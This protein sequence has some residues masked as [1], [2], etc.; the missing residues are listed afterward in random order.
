[1]T[2]RCLLT[3]A[4]MKNWP[5]Y[6][7]DIN[8]AFLHGDLNEKVYMTPP[9]SYVCRGSNLFVVSTSHYMASNKHL[10]NG[11]PNFLLLSR[12]LAL[13]NLLLIILS[14]LLVLAPIS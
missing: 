10:V 5:R 9:P 13:N 6:Q 11:L 7:L 1:M 2:V 3:V 8:N 12:R 4:S 14:L